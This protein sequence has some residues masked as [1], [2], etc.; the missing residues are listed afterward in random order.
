MKKKKKLISNKFM[1]KMLHYNKMSKKEYLEKYERN[2]KENTFVDENISIDDWEYKSDNEMTKTHV[3]RKLHEE[4]QSPNEM[5][6]YFTELWA[7]NKEKYL[8]SLLR[9]DTEGNLIKPSTNDNKSIERLVDDY[10]QE[11]EKRSLYYKNEK[12]EKKD[13]PVTLKKTS[14]FMKTFIKNLGVICRIKSDHQRKSGG[15]L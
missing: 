2:F 15:F 6:V 7:E 3:G 4:I 13:E 9:C 14:E 10:N 12:K 5:L 1:R 11:R 8:R